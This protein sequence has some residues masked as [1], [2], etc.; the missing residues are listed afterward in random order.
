MRTLCVLT[1][2][3]LQSIFLYSQE[4]ISSN[5]EVVSS[6]T[7]SCN[8]CD[9]ILQLNVFEPGIKTFTWFDVDGNVLFTESTM[10]NF[11]SLENL[12]I[13]SYRVEID[14]STD[15]LETVWCNVSELNVSLNYSGIIHSCSAAEEI[16]ISTI[17][18][19][20]LTSGGY[21]TNPEG[22]EVSEILI[23]PSIIGDYT[24]NLENGICL[25]TAVFPLELNDPANSGDGTTYII[26]EDFEEFELL[27]PMA[28]FPDE[29][30]IWLDSNDD[31]H[32]GFFNPAVDDAEAFTYLIDSVPGC[33]DAFSTLTIIKNFIPN[34]GID[35]S[36]FSCQA[37]NESA[38]LFS[39]LNGNP[40]EGGLWYDFNNQL[41]D[42]SFNPLLMEEGLYRYT[43]SGSVPCPADIAYVNVSFIDELQVGEGISLSLCSTDELVDL[44]TF[45][46]D[47]FTAGGQWLNSENES[48]SGAFDPALDVSQVYTYHVEGLGCISQESEFQI[49]NEQFLSAGE[50]AEVTQCES[51]GDFDLNS[52]LSEGSSLEGTWF[53]NNEPLASSLVSGEPSVNSYEYQINHAICSFENSV[54]NLAIDNN[55]AVPGIDDLFVCEDSGIINLNELAFFDSSWESSWTNT[56]TNQLE[57]EFD[58]SLETNGNFEVVVN[59]LNS[60]PPLNENVQ[61]SLESNA[62]ESTSL[63]FEFCSNVR[64]WSMEGV[65][66]AETSILQSLENSGNYQ[67]IPDNSQICPSVSQEVNLNFV[68][69]FNFDELPNMEICYGEELTVQS[70]VSDP[71]YTTDWSLNQESSFGNLF[72]FN[73]NENSNFNN[74]ISYTISDN[75]C[76]QEAEF[77][78][79][80][81]A[82]PEFEIL[83][84]TEYCSGEQT[85]FYSSNSSELEYTW[86]CEGET[87]IGTSSCTF[88]AENSGYI[89]ALATDSN[90]CEFENESFL[91]VNPMPEASINI[92]S[93]A[94][95]APAAIVL[96]SESAVESDNL[97]WQIEGE[98]IENDIHTAELEEGDSL[99]VLLFAVSQEGCANILG[100]ENFLVGLNQTVADFEMS[101]YTVSDISGP[102]EILNESQGYDEV[103]WV[104]NEM[105][106]SDNESIITLGFNDFS[107]DQNEICLVANN[108]NNCPDTLCKSITIQ[109]ALSV[110]V[111]NAFTP[112]NDGLNELFI[113]ILKGYSAKD[114]QLLIFDRWGEIV[115]MSRNPKNG[116]NGSMMGGDYYVP[117]GVYTYQLVVREEVSLV[118]SSFKGSVTVIR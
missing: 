25:N 80:V 15:E 47:D 64:T 36:L 53:L 90:G 14:Y 55:P 86:N 23:S 11:S 115:F 30:G 107:L 104:L 110:Y 81:N 95:C 5:S 50:N 113:P 26:C 37:E 38:E 67:F 102:I 18:I 22:Q 116:W 51:E 6:S 60:C 39:Y 73:S 77:V 62:F 70:P 79:I 41:I 109:P 1:Y 19:E 71:D 99:E 27:E 74:V 46:T 54:L 21:W 68:P 118:K 59:P 48:V 78:I 20:G 2:F 8:S 57:T 42:G 85:M 89:T 45:L 12:C 66:L 96:S 75:V 4:F 16:D 44:N 69:P 97:Y 72:A 76:S 108:L 100:G 84:D 103:E 83:G 40:E 117:P 7:S 28:G 114:Y 52:L 24:Y 31:Y 9:G 35:G 10:N 58:S 33:P 17:E 93:S 92:P 63:E 65:V 94:V 43:V 98:I 112:D 34:A 91:L 88:E 32:D 49:V 106:Y 56:L 61:I 111:P 13:G 82:L 3:I 101:N 87:I 29:N 105:Y